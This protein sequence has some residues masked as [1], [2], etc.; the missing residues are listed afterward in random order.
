[1]IENLAAALVVLQD[2]DKRREREDEEWELDRLK[3]EATIKSYR[4]LNHYQFS[5]STEAPN[6]SCS[7]SGNN[8]FENKSIEN[9]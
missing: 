6:G 7:Y 2:S 9:E 1:M 3:R 4:N 8:S 5:C